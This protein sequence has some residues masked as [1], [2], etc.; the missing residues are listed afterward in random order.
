MPACLICKTKIEQ[1]RYCNRH[2]SAEAM[3]KPVSLLKGEDFAG[4]SPSVFV[5]EYGYPGIRVG[6]LSLP[7]VTQDAWL[8]DAPQT[9]H[10][11]NFNIPKIVSLRS[12]LINSHNTQNIKAKTKTLGL[13][14]EIAMASKHVDLDVSLFKKPH[15]KLDFSDISLP[16]GPSA[17]LKKVAPLGNIKIK[18]A[19]DKLY[20][21][22]I[23]ATEALTILYD[24]GIQEN[25]LYKML[26]VGCF[27]VNERKK[28]VPTR[29]S[30]T[31][32]HD[33][34]GKYL[35]DEIQ[36]YKETDYGY[37]FSGYV[38][39]YFLILFL[40]G[41]WCYELFEAYLPTIKSGKKEW[42]TDHEL[43]HARTKYAEN[44]VG[45]YYASR[46]S[47]LE[48]LRDMK[49][50]G[51]VICIRLITEEYNVPLGVWAMQYA[52]KSSLKSMQFVADKEKM[53]ISAKKIAQEIFNVD[54]TPFLQESQ[55]LKELSSQKRLSAF[56]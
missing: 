40:P 17:P 22:D 49:R 54:I 5:G 14:Q 31:A 28:I 47:V 21:D 25:K 39:N 53:T 36:D 52:T 19:V 27:G 10:V 4:S 50:K 24:K 23:K 7:E 18:T 51:A 33:T 35:I 37:S 34:L 11:G 44:C 3:F 16:Q 41:P 42:T 55:V 13:A 12:S 1:G 9:W 48:K 8:Y 46:L 43:Y 15:F 38:G 45:G 20:F 26:S 2:S 30:I 6:L 56:F 29:W 32:T